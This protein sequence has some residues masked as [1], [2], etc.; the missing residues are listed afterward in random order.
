MSNIYD[1]DIDVS[2]IDIT[3][4]KNHYFVNITDYL[5][6]TVIIL[7]NLFSQTNISFSCL[8][9]FQDD[10]IVEIEFHFII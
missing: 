7:S 5:L 1:K 9:I 4:E 3:N 10:K 8:P 2:F 6:E